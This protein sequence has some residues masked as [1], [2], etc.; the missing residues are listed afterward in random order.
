MELKISPWQKSTSPSEDELRQIFRN[1]GLSPYTWSNGPGD[2]YAAH[3]H[4]YDK[5]I[6]VVRGSITWILPNLNQRFETGAGDRIDLPKGTRHAA[7]VGSSGVTCLEA[8]LR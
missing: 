8:H 2:S 5:V 3:T 7:E 6:F 1:E 4:S